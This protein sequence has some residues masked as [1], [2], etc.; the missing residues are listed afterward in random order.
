MG[1]GRATRLTFMSIH[2]E[3]GEDEVILASVM[4]KVRVFWEI[5][6]ASNF[7]FGV[8]ELWSVCV[9]VCVVGM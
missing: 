6:M 5:S 1:D 7:L 3:S 8:D 9:C 4:G 2:L